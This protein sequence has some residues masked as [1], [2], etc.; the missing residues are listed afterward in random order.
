METN[1]FT[2]IHSP[3]ISNQIDAAVNDKR[4]IIRVISF[5]SNRP[6]IIYVTKGIMSPHKMVVTNCSSILS[7]SIPPIFYNYMNLICSVHFINCCCLTLLQTKITRSL[8]NA[9]FSTSAKLRWILTPIVS[10]VM[11]ATIK[12][13]AIVHHTKGHTHSHLVNGL[14]LKLLTL[15]YN[16]I[17]YSFNEKNSS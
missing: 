7:P 17:Q 3:Q 15:Q 4:T 5:S 11:V 1:F 16:T 12:N 2:R 14:S 13:N 9:N 10:K 6:N 8:C